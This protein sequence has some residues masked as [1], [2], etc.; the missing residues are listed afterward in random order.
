MLR[1]L[2]DCR[3]RN[4][5]DD[6]KSYVPISCGRKNYPGLEKQHS[7]LLPFDMNRPQASPL[8]LSGH[9]LNSR[10]LRQNHLLSSKTLPQVIS[11]NRQIRYPSVSFVPHFLA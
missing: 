11:Y 10:V 2:E 8:C 6:T 5:K 9:L 3:F 7:Y 4:R 1:K